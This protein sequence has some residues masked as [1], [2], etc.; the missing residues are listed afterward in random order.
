MLPGSFNT[1]KYKMGRLYTFSRGP[2]AGGGCQT[3]LFSLLS[4]RVPASSS[5]PDI[6]A[7]TCTLG[8]SVLRNHE[9]GKF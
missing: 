3:P 7:H 9:K 4:S 2:G 8:R 6:R 5:F 1:A